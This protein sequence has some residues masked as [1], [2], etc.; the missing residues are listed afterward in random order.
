[1]TPGRGRGRW[2]TGAGGGVPVAPLLA[3]AGGALVA[4]ALYQ[5]AAPACIVAAG[6]LLTV[7]CARGNRWLL[8]AALV[9]FVVRAV[10]AVVFQWASLLEVPALDALRS[11]PVGGYRFWIVSADAAWYHESARRLVLAWRQGTEFPEGTGPEYFILTAVVYV[12]FGPNPLNGVLWNALLGALAVVLGFRI[13]ARLGGDAAAA[14]AAI[15]IALWPSAV[16]W[17]TQLLKDTLCLALILLLLYL[18][19][20]AVEPPPPSRPR[21]V[22][23]ARWAGLLLAVFVTAVLMH[24]FRYYVLQVLIPAPLVFV[25]HALLKRTRRTPWRVVAPCAVI[26]VMVLAVAAGRRVDLHGLLAPRHPEIG[27]TNLGIAR[28]SHGDL[29]AAETHYRRALVL[30]RDYPPAL[31]GLATI[32]MTRND[33]SGAIGFLERYLSR[34]PADGEARG[35]LEA[36]RRPPALITTPREPMAPPRGVVATAPSSSREVAPAAPSTPATTPEPDDRPA[37][38][39]EPEVAAPPSVAA[40][41]PAPPS[42]TMTVVDEAPRASIRPATVPPPAL[43]PTPVPVPP[44]RLEITGPA[45]DAGRGIR[46]WQY[47]NVIEAVRQTRQGFVQAGGHSLIDADVEL[48]DAWSVLRYLPR[49][50]AHVLLAPYPWQWFDI[51]GGTGAFRALSALE[52]L[53]LY[54]LIVPLVVGLGLVL[55][56]GSPDALYLAVVVGAQLVFLGLVV[57]NVGT[58]FRLRLEP[59]IPLFTTAGV[60]L[61]WI[62]RRPR[63]A[64]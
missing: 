5:P 11:A 40:A 16:L 53:L 30:A 23:L 25:A 35:A 37:R 36:L 9:A 10:L 6:A 26:A 51:G 41:S 32:A 60:G 43:L 64:R 34:Q 22:A 39:V 21:G 62:L 14:P 63:S 58:L 7:A 56:R 20:Q 48:R 3:A 55:R 19:M 17:S 2:L 24:R 46:R 61:L 8:A 33:A 38:A 15:L 57:S 54:A 27:H 18:T 12:L 13:A 31:K 44:K 1:M 29:A 28:Q 52:S 47:H 49:G 4:G 50:L 59:L 42:R 45:S